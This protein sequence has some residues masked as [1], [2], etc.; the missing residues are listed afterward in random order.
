MVN[1]DAM[2]LGDWPYTHTVH[3]HHKVPITLPTNC[4]SLASHYGQGRPSIRLHCY[5]FAAVGPNKLID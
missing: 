5:N 3:Y 2:A 1:L 4:P